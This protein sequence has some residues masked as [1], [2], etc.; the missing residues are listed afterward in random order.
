MND[1]SQTLAPDSAY[2]A[3]QWIA[4]LS[5]KLAERGIVLRDPPEEP[6]SCCGRGC[7]GCVWEGYFNA[8]GYWCEQ[9]QE[10]LQ[11]QG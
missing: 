1:D 11:K 3:R 9:A 10:A 4:G 8:V 2:Q 5:A 6:T 7:N